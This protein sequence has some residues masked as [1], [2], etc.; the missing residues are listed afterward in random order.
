MKL[1][2]IADTYIPA[3]IMRAGL[4]PL[5]DCGVDVEV[6]QWEHESLI[7]LQEANLAIEQGGPEAVPLPEELCAG[8][9]SVEILVVQ[10]AP[11]PARWLRQAQALR[12]I[13]V[14]R[15]G[16]ENVAVAE[17]TARGICVLNTP[18]RN[19]R[20]VAECTLG[21]ILAEVR[22]IARSHAGLR[23]GRWERQFPNS[24]EIPE[25]C[26]KTVGL[27]GYGAVAR[28]VAHY[29]VAFGSRI[30]AYDP[31]CQGDPAPA[32]L[33][34]LDELLRSSD[35]ISLHAR[36]TADNQHL[37]GAAELARMKPTAVLV[38][39][40]RSGLVDE[41]A[42]VAALQAGRIQGAA[43]D[44]FDCEPLPL[45]HPLLRLP[46]V[47]ITPHLAGSTIDA[48]RTSPRLLAGHLARL[49]AGEEHVPI[50]N[51]VRPAWRTAT[52]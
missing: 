46:N 41:A 5:A 33:V 52:S 29:L 17:A 4:A 49:L 27:V 48:F 39:T 11:V 47:T 13:G 26:G 34:S 21:L 44:V 10:F 3:E 45:D 14:L 37:L 15:G 2:A 20:A 18:G 1:L 25:L 36:L 42:L 6:R 19:A 12:V 40:A 22:N 24:R 23:Q 16:T 51:H 28:L 30:I 38:N 50:V 43:L 7:A 32:T 31:Y 35:V 9:E 8:L